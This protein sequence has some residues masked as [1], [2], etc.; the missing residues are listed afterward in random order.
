MCFLSFFSGGKSDI[1]NFPIVLL[2][3]EQPSNLS[4]HSRKSCHG[5]F[6]AD[7]II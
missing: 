5:M 4:A 3:R 2:E 6:I 1:V 7:N